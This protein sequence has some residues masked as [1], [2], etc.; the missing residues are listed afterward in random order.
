MRLAQ[1]HTQTNSGRDG[2]RG[3]DGADGFRI[4]RMQRWPDSRTLIDFLRLR[5]Y[6][7]PGAE[8]NEI[9]QVLSQSGP[10][11]PSLLPLP[12]GP[13][14]PL[15]ADRPWELGQGGVGK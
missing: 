11:P 8:P 15:N 4:P 9:P 2:V 14:Q 10:D 3:G 7:P 5:G 12:R 1:G 13:V 6:P